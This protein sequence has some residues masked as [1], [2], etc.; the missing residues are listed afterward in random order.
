MLLRIFSKTMVLDF[1]IRIRF[2][3][4]AISVAMGIPAPPLSIVEQ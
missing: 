1:L 4:K 2:P 3:I